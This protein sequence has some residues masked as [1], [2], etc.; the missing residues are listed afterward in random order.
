MEENEALQTAR[1]AVRAA[2]R[3]AGDDKQAFERELDRRI[4]QDPKLFEAFRIAGHLIVAATQE[5][6]H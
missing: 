2:H 4:A 5:Q 1:E 3:N 6:R